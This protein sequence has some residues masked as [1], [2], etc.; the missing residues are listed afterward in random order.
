MRLLPGCGEGKS[1]KKLTQRLQELEVQLNVLKSEAASRWN[2]CKES[3][4]ATSRYSEELE[5][6][7]DLKRAED[8]ILSLQE[9]D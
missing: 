8:M 6:T 1:E 2:P 4:T 7:D 5:N 3:D 9:S